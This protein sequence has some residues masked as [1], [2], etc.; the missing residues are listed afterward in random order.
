MKIPSSALIGAAPPTIF[1]WVFLV[2]PGAVRQLEK[3]DIVTLAALIA[4]F[5]A[6][7]VAGVLSGN[8]HTPNSLI[9]A[10]IAFAQWVG[11]AWAITTVFQRV[12]AKK[13]PNQAP[14]PTAPSGR[15]SS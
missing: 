2:G 1:S 10:V 7:F 13:K 6:L 14:E 3:L 9:F 4:N 5:P 15:G 8:V 11:I 12:C